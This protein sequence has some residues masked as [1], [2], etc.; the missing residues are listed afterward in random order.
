MRTPS[1]TEC[2]YYYEDFYRG[3]SVQECRLLARSPGSLPWEPRVC[4]TC[5]VPGILRVNNCPHMELRG[6]LVRRWLRKRVEIAATCVRHQV[7]V[8]DPYV[9]CGRCHP[10]A[11]A[12]LVVGKEEEDGDP[13][14]LA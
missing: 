8:E 11:A 1:G 9:G 12:V 4:A 3:R 6:R 5:P 7:V 2:R 10:A 14:A 13:G